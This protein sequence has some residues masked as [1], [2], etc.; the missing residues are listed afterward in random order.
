MWLGFDNLKILSP[1]RA[2][3]LLV[4]FHCLH[5]PAGETLPYKLTESEFGS[6]QGDFVSVRCPYV[7]V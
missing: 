7:H 1:P 3:V 4:H 6:F 5:G 2:D